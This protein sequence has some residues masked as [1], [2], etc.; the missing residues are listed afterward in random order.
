MLCGVSHQINQVDDAAIDPLK[1]FLTALAGRLENTHPTYSLLKS[2]ACHLLVVLD[3]AST[4][5]NEVLSA[6]DKIK[7]RTTGGLVTSFASLSQGKLIL[8]QDSDES[9]NC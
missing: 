8:E 9:V 1:K 3:S 6:L 7:D 4:P 2:D 5:V